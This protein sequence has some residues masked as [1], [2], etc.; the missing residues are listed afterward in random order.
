MIED[1]FKEVIAKHEERNLI[2]SLIERWSNNSSSISEPIL[3]VD[4]LLL[5]QSLLVTV[6][7]RVDDRHHEIGHLQGVRN[8]TL[9]PSTKLTK[10]KRTGNKNY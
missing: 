9:D 6:G 4:P 1:P 7:Q 2:M 8:D 10:T 3:L 5:V